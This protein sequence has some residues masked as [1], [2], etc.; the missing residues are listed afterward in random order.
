MI[1]NLSSLN[2]PQN[3]STATIATIIPVNSPWLPNELVKIPLTVW[4]NSPPALISNDVWVTVNNETTA[5]KPQNI[6]LLFRLVPIS[7]PTKNVIATLI[8]PIVAKFSALKAGFK[9]LKFI[10]AGTKA[11]NPVVSLQITF[12]HNTPIAPIIVN[13]TK[14]WNAFLI[15]ER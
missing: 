5:N 3:N 4:I 11:P 6:G 12:D 1:F 7:P 8:H 15:D 9:K 2:N 10:T 13:G 14:V